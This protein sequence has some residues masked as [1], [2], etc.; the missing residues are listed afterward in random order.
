[1]VDRII[2][3]GRG[4]TIKHMVGTALEKSDFE[5]EYVSEVEEA[6]DLCAQAR[7]K[8]MIADV[9]PKGIENGDPLTELHESTVRLNTPTLFLVPRDSSVFQRTDVARL[10]KPFVTQA[11]IEATYTMTGRNVLSSEIY[12]LTDEVRFQAPAGSDAD[13]IVASAELMVVSTNEV[14]AMTKPDD[15]VPA[16]EPPARVPPPMPSRAEKK[17]KRTR[18]Q[19]RAAA[20]RVSPLQTSRVPPPEMPPNT[21]SITSTVALQTS[22]VLSALDLD[23]TQQIDQADVV[24]AIQLA[25]NEQIPLDEA[26]KTVVGQ[27]VV[28][29]TI[30]PAT[31]EP[32]AGTYQARDQGD[33]ANLTREVIEKVVWEVVPPLAE[34]LI[35]EEITKWLRGQRADGAV[36]LTS[37][38]TNSD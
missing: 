29:P 20:T 13:E 26:L 15:E 23:I 17:D 2:M 28:L 30:A 27:A 8:L 19:V 33:I 16:V 5:V 25:N 18:A 22:D 4:Q 36:A 6:I 32:S 24:S 1:M 21:Q 9:G 34:A 37:N 7:P 3:L 31:N 35:K 38:Q 14:M 12:P 10:A 11:L